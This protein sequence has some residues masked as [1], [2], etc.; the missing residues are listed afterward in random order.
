MEKN[1]PMEVLPYI[2]EAY[3]KYYDSAFWMRDEALMKERRALLGKKGL[4]AQEILLETVL[5][6]PSE[7]T[8]NEACLEAGLA[9]EVA[10]NLGRIIF[11]KG[12]DFKLRLHQAQSLITSLAPNS[13][14]KRNVVVTSG[15][16]SGKTESFLLPIIA[17]LIAERLGSGPASLYPWWKEPW[18]KEKTWNSLRSCENAASKPAVRALLLYPTNALVEDQISRLRQAAF[19]AQKIHGSPLF[20]FGRYTGATA[21]GMYYPSEELGSKD[22]RKI[23]E[24]AREVKEIEREMERLRGTDPETRA[25][26]SDPY[27]G[28]MMTRWDMID[29]PPDIMITNVS[30]LNVML[31]R[32]NE[33]EIFLKTRKWLE[34][35]PDNHFSLI[36]DELHSYRG[37]QG[38]EVALVVRNLLHRLGLE[39][40]SPQ[41]RCLGTSASLDGEEGRTYLQQFFGVN[42]DTFDVFPGNPLMPTAKLPLDH[43]KV[44][45]LTD[46]VNSDDQSAV[47]NF[48]SEFSPRNAI[49]AA[50]IAAG[51]LAD[52]RHVPARLN[53]LGSQL[54]GDNF[55]PEAL[56]A[57]FNAAKYEK[58][59]SYEKPLPAFRAHMFLRQI[60]GMWACSNPKCDQV[61]EEHRYE[62][63]TIGR[64]FKS[65]SLK[66]NCGGQVLELLYCYDCGE[67]YL[68]GY[69]T[70]TPEGMLDDEGYFLESG[71]SEANNVSPTLVFER[72]YGKY[73]WYWPGNQITGDFASWS[74]K[75]PD[76]NKN[77]TF[78][79]VPASY[80]PSLG[81]L[82]PAAHGDNAAGTMYICSKGSSVA[83]LPE[84][85]PK[86]YSARY[87]S[88][89]KSFFS[90]SVQSPIR[91]QRTGLNVTTQLIAD[92]AVSFLGEDG[93][94]AQMIAFTDSRDDA[95]DV[96]A[97]LELNH[98]RDLMRQVL[99]QVLNSNSCTSLESLKQIASRSSTQELTSEE[100]SIADDLKQA[101][102]DVWT[103]L[104]LDA[105]GVATEIQ[106]KQ[107]EEYV[108]NHM[109][110][111]VISWPLLLRKV[112]KQ[113]LALGI[114][115]A[116]PEV[117]RSNIDGEPWWRFYDPPQEGD[118]EPLEPTIAKDG[119]QELRKYLS[120]YIA[121][122]IFDAGGRDLESMGVA[123]LAPEHDVTSKLGM[124]NDIAHG[125]L[126][127]TLRIL[128]QKKY[129]Q[130]A[131]RNRSTTEAPRPLKTYLERVASSASR[132]ATEFIEN[133]KDVL[134]QGGI[135]TD[136]WILRT[137]NNAGLKLEICSSDLRNLK[138]CTNC[139]SLLL[140]TPL[141]ACITPQCESRIF[142]GVSSSDEDYYRW[143]AGEA[144]HRLHVEELTGQTKPL[145]EQRRRQRCFKGAFIEGE[146]VRV[147][148]IDVLS[149]TTTMEVGVDIGSLNIVMMANM[150]PQRF[151]YQQRVGRAGRA[152]QSFSYA[153]TV[154]RGGSH[155]DFYYNHP[156]RITGDLP[157]QPY[158]DLSR[159]E[160]IKR[161]VSA[162][163]L[164]RAFN[165]LS[166][167]PE[168][169]ADSTHGAFGKANEWE[170]I[171]KPKL[172]FWLES[173]NEVSDVVARLC[174]YAPREGSGASDIEFYCRQ[175]LCNVVSGVVADQK[176][177]QEELSERL[178]TA[179][180]LPM[181][182]FPTQVR[183]L[184]TPRGGDSADDMVVSDRPLD[185]AI[186]AFSPGAEIPKDKQIHTACGFMHKVS[187][188][189][190]TF[191]DKTPLG[192]SLKFSKCTD[193]DCM[194]IA[195]GE[196]ES[197]NVCMSPSEIFN[198]FQPK[199]FRT[200]S[201]P[202][203]Y[204]GQRQ[205]GPT[206]AP[207]ILAFQPNYDHALNL[208]IAQ[209]ALTDQEPIALVNDNSGR[210]YDFHQDYDSVVVTDSHL[211]R[212]DSL[213]R[214]VKSPVFES[215]AIGT[216]FK[217]DVLSFLITSAPDVG[218][219]GVLDVEEQP[220]AEPAIA[221]FGELLRMA[222][223]T[224]LDIDPMEIRIGRQR[225]RLQECVTQQLFLADALE[226]GAGY[227]RRLY[228]KKMLLE[229]LEEYYLVI[230]RDWES[231]SH[232]DCDVSCP[233]CLR[234]YGN[235]M[236]H[237]LLDWR[238]ALDVAELVLGK[239][240]IE[241]RW[242]KNGK[243]V[244]DRFAE[245]CKQSEMDVTA[246]MADSLP[247]LVYQGSRALVLGHPLWHMREGLITD[248]QLNAKYDLQS[249]YGA[250]LSVDFVDIREFR[251]RPQQ[252][253]LKIGQPDA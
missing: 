118:W 132:N 48:I 228:D 94:A 16:G 221:S 164:R 251:M 133:V 105:A 6:Y 121:G 13:A 114:N 64:L 47:D 151:N 183:S 166:N 209:V 63:R 22:R 25:Q 61:E 131:G 188:G 41:L 148:G 56:H 168:R 181:F 108:S 146:S 215:G 8:I 71:S 49:G 27:C 187:F 119:Q 135:I 37:T 101:S 36:V 24:V 143:L 89:L 179:G 73:M 70:P 246:E 202:F 210:M 81:L 144:A 248:R 122:A 198:L 98:F 177:I 217:T 196:H 245:L 174:A 243:D 51:K 116:G 185:H 234:N 212:N 53:E 10:E 224:Y 126:A 226:N 219:D 249:K 79:F 117:S 124:A 236:V 153:L 172:K 165:Q 111:G 201:K 75:N 60:Q 161:V 162:E 100:Q 125:I 147:Q 223:S 211:Y 18:D 142:T 233:D 123:Y 238:L 97:G 54:L 178:A 33:D 102:V 3:H 2:Q 160:I 19:R 103:A 216:V 138:R 167:P 229:L 83:A 129:Y 227:T 230:R 208:G 92:R 192:P 155:D 35:S 52:G 106:L 136:N 220:S 197:C 195:S 231:N 163:V 46:P 250:E 55:S 107:I 182:G 90:G 11:G 30:M 139:S 109:K 206:I 20:F 113:L 180:I 96:A 158:L 173:S 154:C 240:L 69:V 199:G 17:R 253:I 225:Y 204:D 134:K 252:Y 239:P 193:P 145:S 86:C 32:E 232:A 222:A 58:F 82:Q 137:S 9:P 120:E 214:Y 80:W 59:E 34:E 62:N 176:F 184:F 127:N 66:C 140:N 50:C 186:W 170:S 157:P 237:A 65:P 76:T 23:K 85:C 31:M 190:R 5:P 213:E 12:G 130:G 77:A 7:V 78:S 242:L 67:M 159:T 57:V 200:T 68:G 189:G 14:T 205:R 21:G 72:E 235:R 42:R 39:P 115:P 4:T 29:C 44:L 104:M 207:P 241:D 84:K 95:A 128:G 156:E 247:A 28:E 1:T 141:S 149:V 203:D 175:Q 87:Q 99:F 26:F 45:A 110:A 40:D 169:S 244:A 43:E 91:A 112:E 194:A 152:G 150:P 191:A 218:Y 88:N 171:H 15:T 74:H 38:T 93:K